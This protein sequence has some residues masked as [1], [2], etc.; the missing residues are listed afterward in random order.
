MNTTR[1]L[2]PV[3][4]M[5]GLAGCCTIP[6]MI[7]LLP[8]FTETETVFDDALLGKWQE[9]G[10]SKILEILKDGDKG[11]MVRDAD[12]DSSKKD[13]DYLHN[14]TKKGSLRNVVRQQT[15]FDFIDEDMHFHK[16]LN[17]EEYYEPNND[18]LP[19]A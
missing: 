14:K 9:K 17:P 6:E 10:E 18:F 13:D 4:A 15:Y 3:A 1:V 19:R 8:L 16:K 5:L 12:P 7:S 2:I 11:Y